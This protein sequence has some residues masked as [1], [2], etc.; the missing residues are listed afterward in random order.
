KAGQVAR[1]RHR[2]DGRAGRQELEKRPAFLRTLANV[3]RLLRLAKPHS[4]A[5]EGTQ[6]ALGTVSSSLLAF[7]VQPNEVNAAET[8]FVLDRYDKT[9]HG[10][11][12]CP[13]Q[14]MMPS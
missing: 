3:E 2:P 6:A 8:L 9:G 5:P 12:I 13:R 10:L 1:A 11:A 4:A 14:T 7:I